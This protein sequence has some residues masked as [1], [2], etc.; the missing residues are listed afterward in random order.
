[1]RRKAAVL[2]TQRRVER[3]PPGSKSGACTHKGS[4]GTREDR[5]LLAEKTGTGKPE[6]KSGQALKG[7]LPY[8]E[9]EPKGTQTK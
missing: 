2:E 9:S 3:T 4:L 8:P 7:D 5:H 1:M 6:Y